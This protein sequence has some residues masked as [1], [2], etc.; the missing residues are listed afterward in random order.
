[1]LLALLVLVLYLG[2]ELSE[3]VFVPVSGRS[4]EMSERGFEYQSNEFS[5]EPVKVNRTWL[6][7]NLH[8]FLKKLEQAVQKLEQLV[9]DVEEWL[10]A[11]LG[12]G[13][14]AEPCS[15]FKIT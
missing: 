14:P 7:E 10:D 12:E 11:F 15:N 1:T 9:Q 6:K 13:L 5:E 2:M 3:V 4:W 8:V